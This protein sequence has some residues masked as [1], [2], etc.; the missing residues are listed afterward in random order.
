M[1]YQSNSS[2]CEI[3]CSN[4]N[5]WFTNENTKSYVETVLITLIVLLW[6]TSERFFSQLVL[7]LKSKVHICMKDCI[8]TGLSL[9]V[10]SNQ[11]ISPSIQMTYTWMSK[12]LHANTQL[13]QPAC[14]KDHLGKTFFWQ[15]MKS[16]PKR[17]T[18]LKA[19]IVW[20]LCWRT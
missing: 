4:R 16:T 13:W 8:N 10:Y 17:Q 7:T 20:V 19:H 2:S 14:K 3:N 9:R 6:D 15:H 11:E 12:N 5:R 1:I 18:K